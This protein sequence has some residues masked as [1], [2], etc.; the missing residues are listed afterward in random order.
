VAVGLQPPLEQPLGLALLLGDQADDVL[1]Q[2]GRDRLGLD[3]GD[4]AGLVL[5]IGQLED[6]AMLRSRSL[7]EDLSIWNIY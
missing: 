5:P 3:V 1:A 6:R 4:E 2:A 7:Y